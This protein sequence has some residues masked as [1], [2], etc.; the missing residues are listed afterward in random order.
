MFPNLLGWGEARILTKKQRIGD[1][2]VRI[3]HLNLRLKNRCVSDGPKHRH[4]PPQACHSHC[5]VI[6]LI[7]D[8]D[9][10]S[11]YL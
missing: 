9:H 1:V 2:G 10:R 6:H 4:V 5:C 3:A 7:G 8:H 11:N